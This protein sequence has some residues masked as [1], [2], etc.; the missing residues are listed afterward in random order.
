M[1][2]AGTAGFIGA[3]YDG[4]NEVLTGNMTLLKAKKAINSVRRRIYEEEMKPTFDENAENPH[5]S[6]LVAL[7]SRKDG[8]QLLI[9]ESNKPMS[10]VAEDK[11]KS[12]GKGAPLANCLVRTF[13]SLDG[14]CEEAAL[15]SAMALKLIKRFVPGC[16][17][18]T[19][20]IAVMEKGLA[21]L[22][23]VPARM[24][25]EDRFLGFFKLVKTDLRKFIEINHEDA[26]L[27]R[28]TPR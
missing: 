18:G 19:N 2:G 11:Y 23:S 15:I 5:F 6:L 28:R 26:L 7:W 17:G 24:E 14:T 27:I 8:F 12:I 16:G 3:M 20:I 13:Y 21:R 22:R 25:V 1:V 10:I 9:G 4:I